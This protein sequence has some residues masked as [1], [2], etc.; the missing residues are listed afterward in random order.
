MQFPY[1]SASFALRPS[2]FVFTCTRVRY[3]MWIGVSCG[4]RPVGQRVLDQPIDINGDGGGSGGD[5]AEGGGSGGEE[6]EEELIAFARRFWFNGGRSRGPKAR[7][8]GRGPRAP[9]LRSVLRLGSDAGGGGPGDTVAAHGTGA[10]GIQPP[11]TEALKAVA[12]TEMR[13]D[14]GGGDDAAGDVVIAAVAALLQLAASSGL[15]DSA[16]QCSC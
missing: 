13:A 15:G 7:F 1:L 16:A 6:E 9:S 4:R 3:L 10:W 5:G 14:A 2:A 11:P 8:R 12:T